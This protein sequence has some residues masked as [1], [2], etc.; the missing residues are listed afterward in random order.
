MIQ[1][2]TIVNKFDNNLWPRSKKPKAMPE[3]YVKYKSIKGIKLFDSN[4][5]R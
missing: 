2:P 1:I 3:L 4:S 5:L